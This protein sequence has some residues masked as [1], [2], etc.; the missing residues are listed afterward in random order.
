[1]PD[2]RFAPSPSA[3]LH[4]GNL[5]TA[6]IAWLF[7]RSTESRFLVRIEDLDPVSSRAEHVESIL[8]DL[9]SLGIDHD[10]PIMF[11]SERREAH[12][13]AL[14][15]LLATGE[16]YSCFCTRKEIL[17][18]AEAAPRAPH[19]PA[20]AYT[21][22]CRDLSTRDRNE[23]EAAGR[24]PTLRVRGEG[25]S[26]GFVDD[27]MGAYEGTIDDFV[28]RR[29]DG[30]PAYNLAVVVDDHDQGIGQVV[31]GD[32]LLETTP[33]QL[34]LSELLGFAPPQYAHVPLVLDSSGERLAKRHGAVTLDDQSAV[35]RTPKDVLALFAVSL[36]LADEGETVRAIDLIER[37]DPAALG[38]QPWVMPAWITAAQ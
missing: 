26:F 28:V 7:A 22:T 21:G 5:R 4:L 1:M 3:G 9:A 25:H 31:R 10:G 15:A 13:R 2:G 11:Q 27:V 14:A 18:E 38:R 12:E 35:G 8:A 19:A 30:V 32:D 16:T 20:F 37:F 36:G 29:A 6:L 34:F 33:R 23:R 24:R 17:A